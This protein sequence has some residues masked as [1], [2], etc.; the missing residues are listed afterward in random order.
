M[1]KLLQ[2]LEPRQFHKGEVILRD[3]EEVNEIMFIMKGEF[4]VG[5]TVNNQEYL[6]LKMK[7]RNVIGDISIMF[8]RR[9]EFLY[10]ALSNINCQAIRK[11]R[12]YEILD[13]YKDFGMRLKARAFYSYRDII[14][15][16]VLVHKKGV[17]ESIFRLHP[18][19]RPVGT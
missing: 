9:S 16:P 5:Y 3:L 13:R 6:A 8:R 11:H 12:F 17:Y 19:E 15:R 4:A 14:R 1:I 18:D 2:N 7:E 10:R